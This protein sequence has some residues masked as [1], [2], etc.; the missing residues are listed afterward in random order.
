M[1]QSKADFL[2]AVPDWGQEFLRAMNQMFEDHRWASNELKEPPQTREEFDKEM[3]ET[4]TRWLQKDR[5][6]V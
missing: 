6:L 5:E 3:V 1:P 2:L 4:L